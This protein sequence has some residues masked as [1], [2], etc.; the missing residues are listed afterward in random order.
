MVIRVLFIIVILV[1]LI[2][3]SDGDGRLFIGLRL[4]N[5]RG[6]I[7]AIIRVVSYLFVRVPVLVIILVLRLVV[8]LLLLLLFSRVTLAG[9]L[10]LIA[11]TLRYLLRVPHF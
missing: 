4:R 8:L 3:S 7:I 6:A 5:E 10:T 1:V 11:R 2:F 9:L